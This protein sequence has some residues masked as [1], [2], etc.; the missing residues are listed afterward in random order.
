M[1][2]FGCY[3][4][5]AGD[6]GVRHRSIR[7]AVHHSRRY[8]EEVWWV[9]RRDHVGTP[10]EG[11]APLSDR[12]KIAAQAVLIEHNDEVKRTGYGRLW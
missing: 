6:C 3:R 2:T 9:M 7:A 10:D 12:E 8:A 5:E 4:P 1:T 11:L